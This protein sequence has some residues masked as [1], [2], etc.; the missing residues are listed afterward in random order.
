MVNTLKS[1]SCIYKTWNITLNLLL[2]LVY[3]FLDLQQCTLG[4]KRDNIACSIATR[5]V[6]HYPRRKQA[7]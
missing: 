3:F 6:G 2:K 4:S 1:K 5:I 7:S